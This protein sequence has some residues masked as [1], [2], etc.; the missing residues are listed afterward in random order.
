MDWKA[1]PAAPLEA[2]VA[3]GRHLEFAAAVALPRNDTERRIAEVWKR[4]LNVESV[5]VEDNFFDLGANSL[6]MVQASSR[7]REELERPISLVDLFRYPSV[8]A[9]ARHLSESG[10]EGRDLENSQARGRSRL[11]FALRRVHARQVASEELGA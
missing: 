1:L 10:E 4:L 3:A 8:S 2:A 9:L 5:S 7:L 11:D 6:T